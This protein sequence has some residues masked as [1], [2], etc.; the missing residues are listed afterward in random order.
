MDLPENAIAPSLLGRA[1]FT[2]SLKDCALARDTLPIFIMNGYSEWTELN[3]YCAID[4]LNIF[5]RGMYCTE[6]C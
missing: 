4:H 1:N 5:K 3:F 6:T 2:R